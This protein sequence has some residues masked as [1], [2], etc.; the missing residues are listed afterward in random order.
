[1][2]RRAHL[3]GAFAIVGC[4]SSIGLAQDPKQACIDAH[5]RG[6]R[7]ERASRLLDARRT[8]LFCAQEQCPPVVRADCV[9]LAERVVAEIPSIVVTTRS[10]APSSTPQRVIVDGIE[11]PEALLGNEVELDPGVHSVSVVQVGRT[12]EESV[13]VRVGERKR[14]VVVVPALGIQ[15]RAPEGRPPASSSGRTTWILG[16]YGGAALATA[17]FAFFGLRGMSLEE[18][19]SRTCGSRCTDS[20]VSP[21]RTSYAVADVSLLVGA[22]AATFATILLVTSR[23]SAH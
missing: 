17:S 9:R 5:E 11:R 4:W 14:E 23:A 16:L 3:I 10:T 1:M 22:A 13:L 15:P 12:T 20:E 19:R 8:F 7:E 18:E 2:T 6:Q 21:I